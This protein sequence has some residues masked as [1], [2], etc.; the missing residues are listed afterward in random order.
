MPLIL[1]KLCLRR[2]WIVELCTSQVLV[3]MREGGLSRDRRSSRAVANHVRAEWGGLEPGAGAHLRLAESGN[4]TNS[5]VWLET[6]QPI[7][8]LSGGVSIVFFPPAAQ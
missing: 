7:P 2:P 3:C 5:S 4:D 6:D 8:P 1:V